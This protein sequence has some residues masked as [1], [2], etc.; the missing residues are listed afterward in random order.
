V[1]DINF[2]VAARVAATAA[3]LTLALAAA[4]C[5]SDS[6]AD[7]DSSDQDQVAAVIK[8]VQRAYEDKDGSI[9]C[10][11]ATEDLRSAAQRELEADSCEQGFEKFV[12]LDVVKAD[13]YPSDLEFEIDGDR[14]SVTGYTEHTQSRQKAFFKKQDGDWKLALWFRGDKPPPVWYRE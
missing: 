3:C 7:N 9:Y 14:A 5:G 12:K 13:V 2:R 4:S 10:G 1:F 11:V 8:E 6:E